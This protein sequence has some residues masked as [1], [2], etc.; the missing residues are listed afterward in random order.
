M[1]NKTV[2]S[3]VNVRRWGYNSRV[4][5]ERATGNNLYAGFVEMHHLFSV[6]IFSSG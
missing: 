4:D 6:G 1:L 3:E 5:K 2:Q